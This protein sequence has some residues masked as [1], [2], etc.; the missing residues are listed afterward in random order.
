MALTGV[1]L[2]GPNSEALL[3]NAS[4]FHMEYA[5]HHCSNGRATREINIIYKQHPLQSLSCD[6]TYRANQNPRE[7][8]WQDQRSLD[9]CEQQASSIALRLEDRGWFCQTAGL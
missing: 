9:R 7:I 1:M 4:A 3:S 6:V 8:L 5:G 2:I